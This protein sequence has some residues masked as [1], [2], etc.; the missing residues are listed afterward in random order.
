MDA[1][2][3]PPLPLALDELMSHAD[4]LYRYAITRVRDHHAA[5]DLVQDT[6]LAAVR[7]PE[8]FSGQS[9][10]GTW[11]VGILRN[12]IMDYYRAAARKREDTLTALNAHAE[13]EPDGDWFNR[14]GTWETDPNAG[15]DILDRDPRKL[16]ENAEVM[17]AIRECMDKLP[18]SLRQLY[19]LRELDDREP[20]EIC[21]ATGVTRG[22]LA[23]LLHRARQLLR[24]CLQKNFL[25]A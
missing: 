24:A 20:V 13:H 5:E 17:T 7:K 4:V 2:P 10:P 15:L 14:H 23:V 18:P 11:L 19:A 3:Q 8:N 21:E 12:K 22:S 1:S 9:K 6:L 25:N 16:L